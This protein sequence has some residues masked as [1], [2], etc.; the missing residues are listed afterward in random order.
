MKFR[1]AVLIILL[2]SINSLAS[3][4][5]R[6]YNLTIRYR[7]V[8]ITGRNVKAMTINDSIPGPTLRF[9]E[10]DLARI[11][12]HNEMDVETSIHWHGVLLP[13]LQ[14]GVPYVTTPP[15]LPGSTFTYEFPIKH[16]GTY[17]YHSH[18]GLQ[19]QRGVYGSIV[20]ETD[21]TDIKTDKELVVVLSDWTDEDPY[22][23]LRTLKSGS[24][25][26][27]LQKGSLQSLL[28]AV[29]ANAVPDVLKRSR[30]R[31]PPMD[32]S[33]IAYDRFLVNGEPS[34]EFNAL[35]GE[36]I[37]LRIINAAASS[38]F[39][40]QFAGGSMNVISADG[41]I[42]QPVMMNRFLI[43]VAETYDV[44]ITVSD[45]GAYEFRVTAQDGSGFTSLFIG[46]GQQ[47]AAPDVP[48]PN[49]Y[50]MHGGHDGMQMD[51]GM[52]GMMHHEG[53]TMPMEE[54]P[55]PPYDKLRSIN[56]T[57][58]SEEYPVR[59]VILELTGDMERYVW[60]LNGKTL[61]EADMIR[62]KK[63][64][65][66]RFVLVNKTMMHHPMHLHGHFFRVVNKHGDYS[67]LKH[68]VDVPP[69]GTRTIEFYADEEKDWF[70]H[71]HILYHMDAG[72]AR[73]VHYEGSELDPMIAQIRNRLF[74]EHW[75][76]WADASLLTQ[77]TDGKIVAADTRNTFRGVW[78][79]GW[80]KDYE[81][82]LTYERYFDRFFQAFAGGVLTD[83]EQD[84]R[85]IIGVRYLL[86]FMFESSVWLD[87]EGDVRVSLENN[88]RLTDRL[89]AFGEV[90]Y[91]TES[92][93][94]WLAGAGWTL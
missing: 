70:F 61:N 73:I 6:E 36:T 27:S 84:H 15:I 37:R 49:L 26:Y 20:I 43:A 9:K 81:A 71:C 3:S 29:R 16:S 88:I 83:G 60:S 90:Q 14:D 25:Y 54:R 23:V 31:M 57:A 34:A 18:T 47:I 91:D 5:V 7:D 12:V 28:G 4:E 33:D 2:L 64:E 94:E 52:E 56:S 67:P 72:M 42:V 40:L 1:I 76:V 53:M 78:E 17:W 59:E 32:I 30:E 35:P 75:Y 63:G 93:G 86:P 44:I 85:G 58:L 62:I 82:V 89:Y 46:E 55:L 8:N 41:M 48:K 13:N 51:N 38:Y 87:T 21:I 24:D 80:N 77:M 66:V 39:Y 22:K 69:L 74:T 45:K 65:N 79:A 50:K 68:T 11:H 92:K 10:G 19:E